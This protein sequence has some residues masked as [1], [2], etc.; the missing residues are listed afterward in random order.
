MTFRV[1]LF[2]MAAILT[3][4]VARRVCAEPAPSAGAAADW[5]ARIRCD[6]PRLFFNRESWPAVKARALGPD[7]AWYETIKSEVTKARAAWEKKDALGDERDLG[8]LAARL[9]FVFRV[10]QD[11]AHLS[12]ARKAM[13]ASLRHYERRLRERKTVNWFGDSRVHWVLAWDWLYDRL[14]AAERKEWFVRM[15]DTLNGVLTAKPRIYR[16]NLGRH[17]GGYYGASSIVWYAGLA[18]WGEGVRED[19]IRAWLERGRETNLRL[20]EHRAKLAGDDGGS[21]T[22]TLEYAFGHYPYSEPN[23]FYTCASALGE[24]LAPQW[25]YAAWQANYMLWNWIPAERPIQFGYGDARHYSNQ[26]PIH[27]IYHHVAN[28]C[29][30]Y[31]EAIPEAA[32]LARY[33]A[34][35]LPESSRYYSKQ[36]FIHPFLQHRKEKAPPPL[37][38]KALPPARHFDRMGQ[39]F[40]CSGRGP[41]DTYALFACGGT[42]THHRHYDAL[43]FTIYRSGYQALDTGTRWGDDDCA[44]R[45]RHMANYWGQTVAH[46][47]VL[48]HMP[49]EPPASYWGSPRGESMKAPNYGG[50]CRVPGATLAAFETDPAF[51]YAAGDATEAYSDKKCRSIT[52][53]FV[54]LPPVHFVV[55]DRV[56]STR[57][58]YRKDWLIHLGSKP[59]IEGDTFRAT[60]APGPYPVGAPGHLLGRTLLPRDAILR[61]VG[62]PGREFLTGPINWELGADT[63]GRTFNAEERRR[64]GEWRLEVSPSAPREADLFLHVL[65]VGDGAPG[66]MTPCEL[67]RRDGR[68]GVRLTAAGRACEVLFATDGPLAGR[69]RIDGADGVDREL[70]REIMP[71]SG[72]LAGVPSEDL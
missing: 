54:F 69:I 42:V 14:P 44:H 31:G 38:V 48:I 39:V 67:V 16:E 11:P 51:T 26:F 60:G 43:H 33:V 47:C 61:P 8:N 17:T 55:F 13:D 52:R 62:G 41:G 53:Q 29:H 9:A 65:E 27:N 50:Q 57:A 64:I 34:G 32:A 30:L 72:I 24:D 66:A 22:S 35:L 10:E 18:G 71:Q 3:V 20:L 12:A 28:I 4:P 36:W 2:A 6:H 37:E 5:T 23:F 56:V 1:T 15:A 40:M 19:L 45:R 58:E 46:N 49:D 59:E 7:R 68:V 21:G 25:P 70:T 63:K